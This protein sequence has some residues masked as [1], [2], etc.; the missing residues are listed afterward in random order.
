MASKLS[1]ISLVKVSIVGFSFESPW[2]QLYNFG[3]SVRAPVSDDRDN[4]D[5]VIAPGFWVGF[6]GPIHHTPVFSIGRK[7]SFRK[8]LHM[9]TWM[10]TE[11][12]C[13]GPSDRWIASQVARKMGV[14][15]PR[16]KTLWIY[17][18]GVSPH[19]FPVPAWGFHHEEG[20]DAYFVPVST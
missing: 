13:P 8:P 20:N 18:H 9:V 19:R 10:P 5:T 6:N 15:N 4:R 12:A 11:Q 2:W 1:S 17:P 7:V 3:V 14:G 16:D